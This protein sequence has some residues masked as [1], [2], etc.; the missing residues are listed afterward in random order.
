MAHT[1]EIEIKSLLGSKENADKL[2]VKLT[3]KEPK[4]KLVGKGK[5]LNHYFNAPKDLSIFEKAI[6]PFIDK[7]KISSLRQ[8][9]REGKK[10]SIRTR[11]TDDKVLFVLKASIGDGTSANAVSRI[12]FESEAKGKTLQDL[13][14]VLLEAGLTYQAKWSRE[15][16]EYQSKDMNVCIDKNAGYG[17]LA[18][19][20]KVI[21]DE[22]AV[23]KVKKELLDFMKEIGLEELGQDRLERMFAHYNN[24]WNEYYGSDKTFIIE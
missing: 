23:P 16:E 18:E 22:K 6:T 24:H 3:K 5:Q 8:V 19:F 21:N 12:E 9:V 13:D 1:Y 2:K 14:N 4:L 17:Y 11:Q 20:E 7:S 15:R 10:V